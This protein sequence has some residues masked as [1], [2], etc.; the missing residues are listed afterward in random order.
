MRLSSAALVQHRGEVAGE[1]ADGEVRRREQHG[2]HDERVDRQ[3]DHGADDGLEHP[4]EGVVGGLCP[5]REHQ[6]RRDGHL[7][8]AARREA[9]RPRDE[10]ADDDDAEHDPGGG[11]EQLACRERDQHP[12][13]DA[14][15]P[16]EPAHERLVDARQD[17][18]QRGDRGEDRQ[19]LLQ[20]RDR[21]EP[22]DDD[23]DGRLGD[24]E[25]RGAPRLTDA[26]DEV[27]APEDTV[28]PASRS[29]NRAAPSALRGALR[30]VY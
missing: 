25:Q 8:R 13:D 3:G 29:G 27:H 18:Q 16:L 7:V 10:Q 9:E 21:R 5:D 19:G 12:R 22:G 26:R 24:L 28:A 17:D 30:R 14:D 1:A 15:A 6:H 11:A 2:R 20:Q 4:V 23:R